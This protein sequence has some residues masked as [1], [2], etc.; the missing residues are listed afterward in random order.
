MSSQANS[1]GAK[2][3]TTGNRQHPPAS[4][5]PA[6]APQPRKHAGEQQ[7]DG[8]TSPA[9]GAPPPRS[10]PRPTAVTPGAARRMTTPPAGTAAKAWL[11]GGRAG[12]SRPRFDPGRSGAGG[13]AADSPAPPRPLLRRRWPSRRARQAR[14]TAAAQGPPGPAPHRAVVGHEVQLRGLAGLLRGAVR[15]RRRPVRRASALGVFDSI[16]SDGQPARPGRQRQ[17]STIDIASWFEP[18]RILG[19]TAL[20]GA[21]NVVLITALATLG[22]GDL[23]PLRPTS[24]AGSRSPSARPSDPTPGVRPRRG[25]TPT[26]AGR[27]P[28]TAENRGASTSRN[29]V[30]FS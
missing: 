23:Q 12:L 4:S 20:I 19:Y 15:G 30:S 13:R 26:R 9:D 7:R 29:T 14:R 2:T 24:S 22:C 6:A 17:Q 8:A 11:G 18:V 3:G 16:T 5:P 21:V 10:R 1:G 28:P 27:S 25:R